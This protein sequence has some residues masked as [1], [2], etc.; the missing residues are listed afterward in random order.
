MRFSRRLLL[1]I[2][3]YALVPQA[4]LGA[5]NADALRSYLRQEPQVISD[6]EKELKELQSDREVAK[7][8]RA[9]INDLRRN[10]AHKKSE[11]TK[12]RSACLSLL[13]KV[14]QKR[15]I[16]ITDEHKR[17]LLMLVAATGID[18]ATELV[19]KENPRLNMA[20]AEN[21]VAYDYE[22][23]SGGTALTNHLKTAWEEAAADLQTE[24]MAEL[25]DCGA[26]PNW[27]VMSSTSLLGPAVTE[28]PIVLAAKQNNQ[29]AFNLLLSYNASVE[30]RSESGQKLAEL[31][32]ASGN[33]QS[34]IA[35]LEKGCEPNTTFADGRTMFEHLLESGAEECLNVWL[36]K[37]EEAPDSASNLCLIARLGTPR[38][39]ELIFGSRKDSL[40]TE[41]SQGNMPL[42]EAARRGNTAVYNALLKLGADADATNMR[43][44]TSLMHAAL[45]GNAEMLATVLQSISPE[46]LA[47]SDSNGHTAI[48]YARLAKDASAEQ[49]LKAAGLNPHA[50]D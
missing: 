38:A 31:V 26:D 12:I 11:L 21:L 39:A 47:A 36:N 10:I 48:H 50:Q 20:D 9:G 14:E 41:D 23:R 29:E 2:V 42:H 30:A 40:N 19:L 28:A 44:E 16:N 35:L 6:M 27:P 43:G 13:S 5:I 15:N 7:E 8:N 25:L 1:G 33:S 45:S 34:F 17:T 32:I 3:M 4:A 22:R 46:T 24:H 37:A 18:A 49:T